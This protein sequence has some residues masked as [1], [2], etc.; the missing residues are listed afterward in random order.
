MFR[1]HFSIHPRRL[2]RA[3]IR[4]FSGRRAGARRRTCHPRQGGRRPRRQVPHRARLPGTRQAHETL[5]LG[6][7]R[8]H[9]G[10]RGQGDR[11]QDSQ[12]QPRAVPCRR[13]CGRKREICP[14]RRS[15]DGRSGNQLQSR[16][17]R[18]A[19]ESASTRSVPGARYPPRRSTRIPMID[20]IA[21]MNVGAVRVEK[22][23]ISLLTPKV[24]L[25]EE[26]H[27]RSTDPW[28]S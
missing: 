15:V 4:L 11:R 3:G 1:N 5:R 22:S 16:A 6:Q 17:M 27:G 26:T 13:G 23:P 9:R 14:R 10:C 18:E 8:G 24:P 19:V 21:T 20:A 2:R 7:D 12:R 25:S 28:L